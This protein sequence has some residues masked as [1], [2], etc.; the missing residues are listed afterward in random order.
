MSNFVTSVF[1]CKKNDC[2][3]AGMG[4]ARETRGMPWQQK[5]SGFVNFEPFCGYRL[6]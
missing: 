1:F 2:F 3:C 6:G 4:L 5:V